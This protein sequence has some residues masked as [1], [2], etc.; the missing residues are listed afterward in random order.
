[1]AKA[2]IT[3]EIDSWGIYSN[4]DKNSKS[5]PVIEKQTLEIPATI[6]IEFGY[7]LKIYKAKGKK[8]NFCIDHP[9]ILDENGKKRLPFTGEAYVRTNQWDFF[10]GDTIWEPI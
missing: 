6:G 4:W 3:W 9:G 2:K 1:M 8:L 7:I 10:L 5:L